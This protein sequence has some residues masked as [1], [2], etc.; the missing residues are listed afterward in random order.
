ML[1]RVNDINPYY[2]YKDFFT[3]P[4]V[5]F[6]KKADALLFNTISTY[7]ITYDLS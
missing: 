2:K 4:K 5:F 7:S 3:N 1:N 6:E